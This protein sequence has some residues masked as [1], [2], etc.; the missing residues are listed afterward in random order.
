M[1]AFVEQTHDL[2]PPG[3]MRERA[4]DSFMRR[5][6]AQEIRAGQFVTQHQLVA[7][8]GMP[9]GAIRELVPRLEAEGLLRTMPQRGMQIA[10]VDIKLIRD[11]FQFRAF[12]ENGAVAEFARKAPRELVVRLIERHQDIIDR[13]VAVH[14]DSEAAE[15][16]ISAAQDIDW[17][18]HAAI[19]DFLDNA[20]ISEAYRVNSIKIRLIRQQQTTLS[21]A[22]VLP[23]MEDHMA[24]LSAITNRDAAAAVAAMENHIMNARRRAMEIR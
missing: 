21:K 17:A 14:I 6:L 13:C 10:H 3:N 8:T 22:T 4:Y 16:L 24:I 9:L 20:I 15:E 5:L 12:L 23:T 19:I 2:R 1:G 11:A 7:I 18:L